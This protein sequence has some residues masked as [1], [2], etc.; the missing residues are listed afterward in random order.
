MAPATVLIIDS[1]ADSIEIY[2]LLL[3]HHGYEVIHARDGE[4]GLRLAFESNPDLVVSELFLPPV[5][6]GEV[7][8]QL[9][10]DDRTAATPLIVLDSIPNFGHDVSRRLRGLSRLTKPCEPSRLLQEIE[11][12]LDQRATIAH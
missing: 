7:V 4:T 6:G 3:R 11:R 9:R 5:P 1:D 8:D 10:S 2:S 12:L